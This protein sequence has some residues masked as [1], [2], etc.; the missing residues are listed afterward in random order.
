MEHTCLFSLLW[1]ALDPGNGGLG[2]GGSARSPGEE[3]KVHIVIN[4]LNRTLLPRL[5]SVHEN[6]FKSSI[7]ISISHSPHGFRAE[8]TIIKSFFSSR[9]INHVNADVSLKDESKENLIT[10]R[11]L[12]CRWK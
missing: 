2:K 1:T 4:I 3:N 6:K 11:C 8:L 5:S 12:K 7:Y 9:F 10:A